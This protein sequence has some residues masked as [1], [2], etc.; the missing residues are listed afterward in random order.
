MT[1]K[2]SL[3]LTHWTVNQTRKQGADEVSANVSTD[4]SIEVEVRAGKVDKL[5][6][7]MRHGLSLSIYLNH[8]YSSHST[9]DLRRDSLEK[10]IAEAVAMTR[11][12][13]ADPF[14]AL[15]ESKYYEG[16]EN[17][18]LKLVDP[19]YEKLDTT[20][21]IRMAKVI[22]SA[23]MAQSKKIISTTASYNDILSQNVKV[24]SNGF[25][26]VENGTSFS[27]SAGV[28]VDDGQGGRPEDYA[29]A[30]Q[31]HLKE[32]PQAESIG[33]EAA[34][35][36]L[37]KIGQ[38]KIASGR[39]ELLV[40]NRSASRL[41]E[42][43]INAMTGRALQQKSSFLEGMLG[44]AVASDILTILEDP[45]LPSGADS[46]LFDGE[47][48]AARKRSLLEKGILKTYYINNYYGR[49][50][51]MEPTTGWP[52]NLIFNSGE[53][54]LEG[55][56]RGIP[57]GILVSNFIGGNSNGTTGDFSFGI[58]GFYIENG[59][60]KQPVNE[61]NMSGNFKELWKQL[62]ALGNDPFPYGG[63]HIPTLHFR[64]V[65]FSGL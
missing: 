12:L 27:I 21:R 60:I 46:R 62:I 50:M 34:E 33:K 61:M 15:P 26:G 52:A 48:I 39:Y 40:E 29:Y 23:A 19:T 45:F 24:H 22:E 11:H 10:F 56:V 55:L 44:K 8:R 64:D 14:R 13:A 47:G 59:V 51:Q 32:L 30:F 18:D 28:T 5:Q 43:L 58:M 3:E 37:H 4:R 65:Q 1:P 2:E 6:E 31:R 25:E 20:E 36:S 35:R 41:L 38:K 9:N 63:W 53:K 7:S 42:A 17:R 49:K 57:K 16:Q 54:N